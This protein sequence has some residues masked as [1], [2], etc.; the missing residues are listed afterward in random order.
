[1]NKIVRDWFRFCVKILCILEN[2][3]CGCLIC[4]VFIL[5]NVKRKYSYLT[6][7]FCL[8]STGFQLI[9]Y[10]SLSFFFLIAQPV[11]LKDLSRRKIRSLFGSQK[12]QL[13]K[14]L[15]LPK[16]LIKYLL[17]EEQQQK[18]VIVDDNIYLFFFFHY[19]FVCLFCFEQN[20]FN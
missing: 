12:L 8:Y 6:L 9:K 15:D 18:F 4:K 20:V 2:S 17:H 7:S 10:I 5:V 14:D 1:M 11:C 3:N 19:L 16:C 13:M